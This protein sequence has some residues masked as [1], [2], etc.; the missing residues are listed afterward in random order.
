MS[1]MPDI[2]KDDDRGFLSQLLTIVGVKERFSNLKKKI[3][4]NYEWHAQF[5]KEYQSGLASNMFDTSNR[6]ASMSLW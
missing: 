4:K 2:N 3:V 5:L 6:R 1:A